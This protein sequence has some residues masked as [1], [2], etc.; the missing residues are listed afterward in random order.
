MDKQMLVGLLVSFAMP[1]LLE[2]LKSYKW[3]FFIEHYGPVVNRV[4]A[5][6]VAICTALGVSATFDA[7]H[8]TLL[9]SG[10]FAGQIAQHALNALMNLVVQELV[11]R[12][13]VNDTDPASKV[14]KRAGFYM[15]PILIALAL[16]TSACAPQSKGRAI[17]VKADATIAAV[18]VTIQQ[19]ADAIVKDDCKPRQPCITKAQRR[20]MSPALLKAL[21]LGRDFNEAIS[22]QTAYQLV[23]GPLLNALLELKDVIARVVPESA[24][25]ALMGN[26]DRVIAL[27]GGGR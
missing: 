19:E 4:T 17:A 25:V 21:R 27:T 22:S 24:R 18:L 16:S 7:A 14:A 6:A 15:V 26:V 2:R 3:A 10:L 20:E 5:I 13:L 23:V 12:K 11:Y 1:W 8:G 9:L